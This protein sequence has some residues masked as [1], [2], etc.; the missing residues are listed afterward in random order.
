M[1]NSENSKTK[2]IQCDV[3]VIGTGMAGNAA[4][5]FA[6]NRGLSVVQMG[7]PSEILF[8]SG[9][10][11][12]MGIHPVE[13]KRLWQDPWAGIEAVRRDIPDHPYARLHKKEI[14]SAFDELLSFLESSGIPYCRQKDRNVNA[15]TP[16]GTVKPTY[17]VPQTM[18]PGVEALQNKTPCLMVDIR[19]LKGF[20]ARQ[21]AA[22]LQEKWPGIRTASITFPEKDHLSAIYTEHMAWALE[23]SST[24][25]KLSQIIGPLVGNS[26]TVGMPAIFGLRQSRE[27]MSDVENRVGVPIF[28]IPTMIPTITGLRLKK[29]FEQ[30]LPDKGVRL[31]SHRHVVGVKSIERGKYF[32]VDVGEQQ[33]NRKVLCRGIVLAS[34]RFLGKGLHA[35]RKQIRETVFDLPVYQPWDRA[36]WHSKQFL[37]PGG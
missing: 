24:R 27:I 25:E 5:L 21:I 37:D 2:P 30:H 9:Y 35:E 23:S 15:L 29:V 3:V 11:D 31:F 19:G 18:W 14:Q 6:V 17:C 4:A 36:Q 32:L 26:R 33:L 34:G 22:T 8:A 1:L 7:S 16:L 20:S 12:L 10:L 28:E 13:E